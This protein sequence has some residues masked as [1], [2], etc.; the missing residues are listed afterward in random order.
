VLCVLWRP[1]EMDRLIKD[2]LWGKGYD[3]QVCAPCPG[4]CQGEPPAAARPNSLPCVHAWLAAELQALVCRPNRLGVHGPCTAWLPLGSQVNCM[5]P[6]G[7]PNQ[8]HGSRWTPKSIAWLPLDSQINCMAPAGHPNQLH[9]SRW[10]PKS[11][12]WLPLDSQ[13]N[14]MAPTGLPN[15]LHA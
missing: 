13:I 11:I 4:A 9:G 15:Q 3:L 14:C 8:L 7:L 5:A 2:S 10:T 1:Q 12:A 6:A